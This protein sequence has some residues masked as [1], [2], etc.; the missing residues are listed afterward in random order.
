VILGSTRTFLEHYDEFQA[1]GVPE[2]EIAKRM[3]ITATS[4]K[5]MLLRENRSCGAL[6]N[7]ISAEERWSQ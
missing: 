7:S 2:W 6:L 5:R 4:L 1:I 3:G